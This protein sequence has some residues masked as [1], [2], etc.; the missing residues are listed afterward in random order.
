MNLNN[1]ATAAQ[2]DVIRKLRQ[3]RAL[4]AQQPPEAKAMAR[5]MNEELWSFYSNEFPAFVKQRF[6]ARGIGLMV[7]WSGN[8]L[9][10][11]GKYMNLKVHRERAPVND[12][13]EWL[14]CQGHVPDH[15]PKH[16]YVD[17][18]RFLHTAEWYR[19]PTVMGP[20]TAAQWRLNPVFDTHV[21]Y[22]LHELAPFYHGP[23]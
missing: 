23:G 15:I 1:E 6:Y 13:D 10:T 3:A 5:T 7:V 20:G 11:D 18:S 16:V 8:D 2:R 19:S 22:I 17:I 4:L 9:S 12:R 14:W 21:A